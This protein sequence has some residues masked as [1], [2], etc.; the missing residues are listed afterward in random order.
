MRERKKRGYLKVGKGYRKDGKMSLGT[1]KSSRADSGI[2]GIFLSD[3]HEDITQACP[4][5]SMTFFSHQQ[6]AGALL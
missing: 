4:S 5:D 2:L 3:L 6:V 1:I